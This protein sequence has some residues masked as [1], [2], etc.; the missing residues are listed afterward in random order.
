MPSAMCVLPSGPPIFSSYSVS[1]INLVMY[2]NRLSVKENSP[3]MSAPGVAIIACKTFSFCFA[4][5]LTTRPFL[6]HSSMPV[7]LL[8]YRY[9]GWLKRTHPSVPLLSGDVNNS[10]LGIFLPLPPSHWRCFP[11]VTHKSTS[12]PLMCNFSVRG[13]SAFNFLLSISRRLQIDFHFTIGFF[14]F[15]KHALTICSQYFRMVI[16]ASFA[17]LGVPYNPSVHVNCPFRSFS[18]SQSR[19]F[20]CATPWRII[21]FGLMPRKSAGSVSEMI[22]MVWS[23]CCARPRKCLVGKKS[24]WCSRAHSKKCLLVLECLVSSGK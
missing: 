10:K 8:P 3:I 12:F 2:E 18:T 1:A 11:N 22:E 7:I 21:R 14:S 4:L 20:L 19:N 15:K 17:I 13:A 16:P 23:I 5:V 24:I 6:N 9:K